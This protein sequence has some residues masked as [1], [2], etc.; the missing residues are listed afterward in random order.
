MCKKVPKNSCY[1]TPR[2]VQKEVC[3]EET[4]R[5]CQKFTSPSPQLVEKQHCHLEPKKTCQLV[6][7][8]RSKKAKR[9]SY[10]PNCR[11]VPRQ[12][13]D[14]LER[15]AVEPV[16]GLHCLSCVVCWALVVVASVKINANARLVS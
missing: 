16:S 13:C 14:H 11:S 10:T 2:T 8:T 5:Y 6:E 12:V 7:R 3:H 15:K 1:K 9:Y 4:E